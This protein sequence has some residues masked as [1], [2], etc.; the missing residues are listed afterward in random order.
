MRFAIVDARVTRDNRR[1]VEE[2]GRLASTSAQRLLK[3]NE[4]KRFARLQTQLLRDGVVVPLTKKVLT[5]HAQALYASLPWWKKLKLRALF[6]LR[7]RLIALRAWRARFAL[8]L[9]S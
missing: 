4:A 2:F 8:R 6:H 3:P 9:K 5:E 7:N 1:S